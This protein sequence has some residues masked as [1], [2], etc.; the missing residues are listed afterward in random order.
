MSA[1][2]YESDAADSPSL[3]VLGS[4]PD[5]PRLRA[6]KADTVRRNIHRPTRRDAFVED[7][8]RDDALVAWLAS[9]SGYWEWRSRHK[10]FAESSGGI[11]V[12]EHAEPSIEELDLAFT[13]V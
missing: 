2:L 5:T 3:D 9:R 1:A 12:N 13:I 10:S 4:F 8:S 11:P 7:R 6:E